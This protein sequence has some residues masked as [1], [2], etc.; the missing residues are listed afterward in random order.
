MRL[1]IVNGGETEKTIKGVP[2][3]SQFYYDISTLGF[4][5]YFS[6]VFVSQVFGVD[7][8]EK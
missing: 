1:K 5:Y 6:D 4:T 8:E 7:R 2:P 3:W